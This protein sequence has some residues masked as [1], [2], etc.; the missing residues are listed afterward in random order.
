M[1]LTGQIWFGLLLRRVPALD[2]AAARVAF[3][4][5]LLAT[6]ALWT[7]KVAVAGTVF[8]SPWGR[9]IFKVLHLP[10]LS[11]DIVDWMTLGWK[12]IL[13]ACAAGFM[14]RFL[15]PVALL[16]L[17][18]LYNLPGAFGLGY[19]WF[20][21][22]TAT[23]PLFGLLAFA[24]A[25]SSDAWSVDS[26]LMRRRGQKPP[27][28]MPRSAEYWWPV[29]M[30]RLVFLLAMFSAGATKLWTSGFAWASHEQMTRLMMY[31][32]TFGSPPG[33]AAAFFIARTPALAVTLGAATL[34]L[35]AGAPLAL[36]GRW[37]RIAFVSGLALMQLSIALL[38][39]AV[40]LPWLVAYVLFIDWRAAYSWLRSRSRR[41][42]KRT[43][44]AATAG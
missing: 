19:N 13:L 22:H 36:L 14:V 18:Y 15:A 23:L 25:R 6:H 35:E 9:G 2:L 40:F 16:L 28:M 1:K 26:W 10:V 17:V 34:V 7:P 31:G 33:E 41:K 38:M 44:S 12:V 39:G 27:P 42:R 20:S 24:F 11:Q 3:F 29:Q 21:H 32:A 8:N 43:P 5:T 30:V 37:P 4:L